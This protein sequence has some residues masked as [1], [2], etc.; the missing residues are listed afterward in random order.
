[1]DYKLHLEKK[2]M[3]TPQSLY[4]AYYWSSYGIFYI[5]VLKHI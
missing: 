2:E 5:S 4:V 3:F 1:M